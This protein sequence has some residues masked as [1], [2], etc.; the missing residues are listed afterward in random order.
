LIE[1]QR[2]RRSHAIFFGTLN[3]SSYS[4]IFRKTAKPFGRT[5]KR[6]AKPCH[7]LRYPLIL[8]VT[9]RYS[10]KRQSRL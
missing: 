2:E 4:P 9:H 10:E 3:P 5:A 7:L 1:P 8:R 6:T